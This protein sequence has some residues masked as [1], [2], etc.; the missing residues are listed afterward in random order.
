MREKIGNSKCIGFARI[1]YRETCN[2]I[3]KELNGQ[4]FPGHE[5]KEKIL[6]VKLADSGTNL[7]ASKLFKAN[8][9]NAKHAQI[10]S[11][12][13]QYVE[14]VLVSAIKICSI[15]NILI[16]SNYFDSFE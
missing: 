11:I 9:I 16:N 6:L 5:N 13:P 12:L 7:K 4:P 1:D 8:H 15:S 3:I 14:P 2:R 10:D